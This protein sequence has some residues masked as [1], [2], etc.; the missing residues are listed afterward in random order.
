M[1]TVIKIEFF[2]FKYFKGKQHVALAL[3]SLND[4][5][6][7]VKSPLSISQLEAN[8][9]ITRLIAIHQ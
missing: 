6:F 1:P 3:V 5:Q 4:K 9:H 7:I 8:E 2:F